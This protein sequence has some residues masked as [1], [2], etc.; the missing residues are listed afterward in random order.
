M[1]SSE[2]TFRELR[3][4]EVHALQAFYNG[5]SHETRRL[6]RPLGWEATV[7]ACEAVCAEADGPRRHDLVIETEGRLVGWGFL[8][9]LDGPEPRLGIGIAEPFTERGLGRRLMDT[10]IAHARDGGAAAIV[11]CHVVDNTRAHRVYASCGFVETHRARH[12]DG[13]DYVH[14][15]LTLRADCG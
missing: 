15:R 2:T 14:M 8:D 3:A 6:F 7:D 4:D 9:S 5:L 11:L 10:L 13:L 1:P 12:D